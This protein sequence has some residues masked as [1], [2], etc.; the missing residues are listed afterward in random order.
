MRIVGREEFLKLPV[1]TVYFKYEP[2]HT[3]GLC[4]KGESLESDWFYQSVDPVGNMENCSSSSEMSEMTHFME[5]DP[6][7]DEPLSFNVEGRDGCFEDDQLFCVFSACDHH[8]LI[9]RL[10]EAAKQAHGA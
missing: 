3:D 4:I 6:R 9:D 2:I 8:R 5:H 1:G 10:K 7:A